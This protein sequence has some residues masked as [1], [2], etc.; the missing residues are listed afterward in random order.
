MEY[1]LDELTKNLD[2]VTNAAVRY[3]A[4][5][6]VKEQD[7]TTPNSTDS[8]ISKSREE[9]MYLI[10]DAIINAEQP[11]DRQE[12]INTCLARYRDFLSQSHAIATGDKTGQNR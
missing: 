7:A 9:R 1:N 2:N 4:I 10:I 12:G 11:D 5:E 3:H 6:I 8:F